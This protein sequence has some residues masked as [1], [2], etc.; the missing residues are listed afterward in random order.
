[1]TIP[2][3]NLL[4]YAYDATCPHH[5]R[6]RIWWEAVLSGGEPVGIPW[7]VILAFVRLSTHPGLM[8]EP[9]QVSRAE[10]TVELW[11]ERPGV[12]LLV[13]QGTTMK[14]FFSLLREAGFGG[15]LTT[16]ALIAA[17]ALECGGIIH[18]SDT[19]FRRFPG[20]RWV[21]PLES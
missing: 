10:E 6:A 4:I 21:N 15:N 5:R 8:R 16:D 14:R 7:I 19:D 18:S 9:I 11:L 13:P 3:V 12:E 1:M 17:H 2:D 20:I